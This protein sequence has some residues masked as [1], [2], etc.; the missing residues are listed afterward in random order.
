MKRKTT[1]VAVV[2]AMLTAMTANVF[3]AGGTPP[4]GGTPPSA[5][6]GQRK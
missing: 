5:T 3:A 4:G 6:Q 2:A 1:A